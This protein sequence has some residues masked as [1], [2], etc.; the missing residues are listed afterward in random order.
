MQ[1]LTPRTP[2]PYDVEYPARLGR[3]WA[4]LAV[5]E[6]ALRVVLYLLDTPRD[7]RHPPTYR[8]ADLRVGESI[9]E[10]WITTWENFSPLIAEY[11]RRCAELGRPRIDT[12]IGELRN[13]LAHGSISAQSANEPMTLIRYERPRAGTVRVVNKHVLTL[14]WLSQ[15]S[16]RVF[17]AAAM[18]L[19]HQQE[20]R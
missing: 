19:R 1:N 20:L 18:V 2:S 14:E 7:Q 15:Q 6:F 4:N 12:A 9:P 3:L 5:L 11:N 17:E 13:A 16:A 8:V 10:T